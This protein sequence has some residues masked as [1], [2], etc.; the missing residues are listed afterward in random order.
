MKNKI[1]AF[2]L[3]EVLITLAIIGVVTAITI[4]TVVRNYQKEVYVIQLKKAYTSV[5]QSFRMA[6]AR[7][8]VTRLQDTILWAKMPSSDTIRV[9]GATDK[10]G[11]TS[12]RAIEEKKKYKEFLDEFYKV[13]NAAVKNGE[14]VTTTMADIK[15][16]K[17]SGQKCGNCN[18]ATSF[19]VLPDGAFIDVEFYSKPVVSECS[20]GECGSLAE[21]KNEKQTSRPY[22]KNL[23]TVYIDVNGI[24]GPNVAGRDYFVFG[25]LEDGNLNPWGGIDDVLIYA[26][27]SCSSTNIE[28]EECQYHWNHAS[29]SWSCNNKTAKS[30]GLSCA[31]RIVEQGWK[32]TY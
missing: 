2:T 12:S 4:P 14:S 13:F 23:G 32:M 25:I 24:K 6:M 15:Y 10:A 1:N 26:T 16:K 19:V 20:S 29:D 8:G 28:S 18:D 22:W 30:D 27:P 17:L 7:D 21:F 11:S 5:V 31:G 3:A 9:K